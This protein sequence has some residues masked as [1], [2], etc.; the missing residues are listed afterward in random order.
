MGMDLTWGPRFPL[1]E[2]MRHRAHLLVSSRL[3]GL[4]RATRLP[5]LAHGGGYERE[6]SNTFKVSLMRA[7]AM[8]DGDKVRILIFDA[9]HP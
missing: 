8:P 3:E 5:Y 6:N 4:H 7:A 1:Q 9:L 2:A